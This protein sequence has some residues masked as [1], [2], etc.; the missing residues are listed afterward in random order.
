MTPSTPG[1]VCSRARRAFRPHEVPMTA[2]SP[3]DQVTSAFDDADYPAYTMGRAPRCSASRLSSSAASTP[4]GCSRPTA[5]PAGTAV[6]AAPN[7]PSP[8]ASANSSTATPSSPRLPHRRTRTRPG[9]RP[10]PDHRTRTDCL[11]AQ[12]GCSSSSTTRLMTSGT[13]PVTRVMPP[14]V[15]TLAGSRRTGSA[16]R[17]SQSWWPRVWLR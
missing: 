1:P 4:Q 13:V 3:D 11:S 10:H 8:P 12:T 5:P 17:P 9:R 2:R 16:A 15:S 6:T 7:S 14:A